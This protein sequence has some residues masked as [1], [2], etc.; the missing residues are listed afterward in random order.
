MTV[1]VLDELCK[2]DQGLHGGEVLLG[3]SGSWIG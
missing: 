1:P 3:D 2:N